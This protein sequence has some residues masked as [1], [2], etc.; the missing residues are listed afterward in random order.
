MLSIQVARLFCRFLILKYNHNIP[1]APQAIK[2]PIASPVFG[3]EIDTIAH[4][5]KKSGHK[6]DL[7]AGS[8]GKGRVKYW[9]SICFIFPGVE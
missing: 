1:M 3:F 8:S 4:R 7:G 6:K 5:M 2:L 9:S